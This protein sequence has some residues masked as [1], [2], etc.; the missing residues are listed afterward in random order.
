MG[1][2]NVHVGVTGSSERLSGGVR[3]RGRDGRREYVLGRKVEANHAGSYGTSWVAPVAL[4]RVGFDAV[5]RGC[6]VCEARS[7]R[8][9]NG[10]RILSSSRS[11]LRKLDNAVRSASRGNL[12]QCCASRIE[13]EDTSESESNDNTNSDFRKSL[14]PWF[15]KLIPFYAQEEPTKDIIIMH[16]DDSQL[17]STNSSTTN[18]ELE[19]HG[20]E[21]ESGGK[22]G[23]TASKEARELEEAAYEKYWAEMPEALADDSREYPTRRKACRRIVAIGDVHGDLSAFLS[24]LRIAGLI[25]TPEQLDEAISR[26]STDDEMEDELMWDT[27]LGGDTVLVQVGDQLDRGDEERRVLHLLLSLREQARA[28]GGDVFALLGNHELMNAEADFRY[29]TSGGFAEFT[30]LDEEL[31]GLLG[32]EF[33]VDVIS[34]VSGMHPFMRTRALALLPGGPTAKLLSEFNVAVVV[35][36]IAFVHGG[37][38]PPHFGEQKDGYVIERLNRDTR[39]FLRGEPGA[40]LPQILGDASSRSPVWMRDYSNPRPEE[41][42]CNRLAETLQLM[43]ADVMVVGHTPQALGINCA[44]NGQVWRVDTG[45]SSAYGGVPECLEILDDGKQVFVLTENGRVNASAR[46]TLPRKDFT[47]VSSP[48]SQHREQQRSRLL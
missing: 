41:H 15:S 25:P 7:S 33:D 16:D 39:R 24:V 4:R 22:L 47:A 12:I 1:L 45:L 18:G 27:W 35:G 2:R 29:V 26:V 43:R 31:E 30:R 44:C 5:E 6:V 3:S 10:P 19:T 8:R 37:L 23:E 34:T 36:S 42:H 46:T 14:P 28:A 20:A 21:S 48:A 13:R 40:R 38:A 32:C 17:R 11:R 9:M